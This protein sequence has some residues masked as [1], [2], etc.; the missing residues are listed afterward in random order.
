M[1]TKSTSSITTIEVDGSSSTVTK[2]TTVNG[3]TS[4]STVTKTASNNPSPIIGSN[5]VIT[6]QLEYDYL[7]ELQQQYDEIGSKEPVA[8]DEK[9]KAAWIEKQQYIKSQQIPKESHSDPSPLLMDKVSTLPPSSPERRQ[10]E[11]IQSSIDNTTSGVGHG[12]DSL[13]RESYKENKRLVKHSDMLQEA[14][15]EAPPKPDQLFGEEEG[16]IVSNLQSYKPALANAVKPISDATGSHADVSHSVVK[17]SSGPDQFLSTSVA[18]IVDRVSPSF[19]NEMNAAY[20]AIQVDSMHH[21][22]SKMTGSIHHL[23]H[24]SCLP[25]DLLSDVY[26]GLMSVINEISNLLD[27]VISSITNFA[28]SAV[29]GL[30]NGLF[31]AGAFK[32]IIGPISK[33]ASQIG[34][35]FQTLGGFPALSSIKQLV[36]DIASDIASILSDVA[37]LA[38][39]FAAGANIASIV[40]GKAGKSIGC[41]ADQ[42]DI[43][44]L[45]SYSIANGN[46]ATKSIGGVIGISGL[47]NLGLVL[48]GSYNKNFGSTI[49]NIRHPERLIEG[50]LPPEIAKS[51]QMLDQL[52]CVVGMVGNIGYSV[53]QTFANLRDHTFS[54][55]MKAHAAHS[56]ILSPLFNKE[57]KP[58]GSYA[59]TDHIGS[60]QDSKYVSGAQG[61]KGVTM[62]GP[63]ATISQRVF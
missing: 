17:N 10:S 24:S 62:L 8:T 49:K 34:S 42:L 45:N 53:G 33:L 11:I 61:A 15:I 4:S 46:K 31:P 28:I 21:M 54:V 59:Q 32:S 27:G 39:L 1:P 3:T 57:C 6:R 7:I 51:L 26:N 35:L 43:P 50:L 41:A 37:K 9:W 2:T 56:S 25:F 55:S 14:I 36:G 22:P 48:S 38:A 13:T 30:V 60:F 5:G 20:K 47:G 19:T 58:V 12:L 63:G 16:K 44:R 52:C 18:S 40:G 29:G 23:S